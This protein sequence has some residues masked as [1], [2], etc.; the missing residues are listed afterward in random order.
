MEHLSS[1]ALLGQS[2][3]GD[4][5]PTDYL[6]FKQIAEQYP[7]TV[8]AGTLPVWASTHRYGFHHLVTKIGRKSRVRRDRWEQFLDSRTIGA[9]MEVAR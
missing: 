4:R 7:G 3:I 1:G 5:K 2:N 8:Q 9:E 6:S